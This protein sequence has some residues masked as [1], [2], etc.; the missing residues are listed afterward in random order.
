MLGETTILLPLLL[1]ATLLR[2]RQ[3][4]LPLQAIRGIERGKDASPSLWPR[5]RRQAAI[6]ELQRCDYN[7]CS[8]N[9]R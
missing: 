7:E 3:L 5:L 8:E 4:L 9:N 1:R 2:I 6:F